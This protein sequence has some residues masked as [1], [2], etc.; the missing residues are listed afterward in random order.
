M[1]RLKHFLR[2]MSTASPSIEP[3]F[4]GDFVDLKVC[5]LRYSRNIGIN[6]AIGCTNYY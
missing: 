2:A 5:F 4:K 3:V 1:N 6:I